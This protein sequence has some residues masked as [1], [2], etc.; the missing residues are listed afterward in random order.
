MKQMIFAAKRERNDIYKLYFACHDI[1]RHNNL[2][3]IFKVLKYN[4]RDIV[5]RWYQET[6]NYR[7]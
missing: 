6:F 3:S 2:G 7:K 4:R 1:V 5:E